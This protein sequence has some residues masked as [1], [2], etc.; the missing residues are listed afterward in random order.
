MDER[1]SRKMNRTI[2]KAVIKAFHYPDL[3]SLKA[4]VLAF[5]YA[6]NFAK[7]V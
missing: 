3:D 7:H 5:V 4:S 1:A 6:A 2:K